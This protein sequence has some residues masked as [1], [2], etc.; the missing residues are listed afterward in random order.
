MRPIIDALHYCHDMGI[1][2]RDLKVMELFI[3]NI[4]NLNEYLIFLKF[5]F[6]KPKF[7]N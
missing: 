3:S 4:Y 5:F 7:V 6:T 1:A 2:H